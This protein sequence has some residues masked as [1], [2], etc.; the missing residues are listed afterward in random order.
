MNFLSVP[1]LEMYTA[2][3]AYFLCQSKPR[4]YCW[5]VAKAS[6]PASQNSFHKLMGSPTITFYHWEGAAGQHSGLRSG[7]ELENKHGG[8]RRTRRGCFTSTPSGNK[9]SAVSE[10]ASNHGMET[11]LSFLLS[12]H[13]H[14]SGVCFN[15]WI[16]KGLNVGPHFK[17]LTLKLQSSYRF[18]ANTE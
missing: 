15:P 12:V 8:S 1:W 13:K 18:I 16:P 2:P 17:F 4:Y 3:R 14:S 11:P 9:T 5:R 10:L 7:L 6:L